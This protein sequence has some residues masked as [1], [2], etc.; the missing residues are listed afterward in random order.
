MA[1]SVFDL[2]SVGIGP[3]SSHTVG[4][5]RAARTFAQGLLDSGELDRV[6]RVR[7]ELYGSL[8]ATG[9]GHGTDRA[10]IL[11][12]MGERPETV[13]PATVGDRVAAAR[14]AGTVHI[15][16]KH[17]VALT[18]DDLVF[19]RRVTLPFHPNGMR[20]TAIDA[21]DDVVSERT[22]YSV[23]GGFV[24]DESATGAD[25]I[26]A[27]DTP[28]TYPFTTGEEL[29]QRCAE[30]GLLD[31]RGDAGQRAGLAQRGRGALGAAA[32]LVGDAG[33]RA[34]RLPTRTACCP[35]G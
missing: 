29:L 25:R 17:A 24:V 18:R 32:H 33:V 3:S 31:Q 4:P 15:L 28:Q 14:E 10:V 20:F 9:R 26:K 19:N 16:G 7:A 13:D 21:A 5:M 12:L 6:V 35:A 2:F 1:V 8:G 23:G 22:F 11:G 30:S 34:G 27:D